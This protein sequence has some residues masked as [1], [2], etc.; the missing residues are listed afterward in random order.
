MRYKGHKNVHSNV[1]S[2]KFKQK[3]RQWKKEDE[4]KT[5]ENIYYIYLVLL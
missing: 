2:M 5:G 1:I 3:N 4:K